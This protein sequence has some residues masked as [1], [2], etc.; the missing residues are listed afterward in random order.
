MNVQAKQKAPPGANSA[1]AVV[2]LTNNM[3]TAAKNLM[4]RADLNLLR[5]HRSVRRQSPETQ[6]VA[7]GR[8]TLARLSPIS[9]FRNRT[10]K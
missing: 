3:Q 4:C 2:A 10:S 9:V 1:M 5:L 6:D 7:N 8:R